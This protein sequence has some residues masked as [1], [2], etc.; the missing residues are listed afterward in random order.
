MDHISH[1]L[2]KTLKK[3]GL[4]QE[5]KASLIV[6]H[7]TLWLHEHLPD[8]FAEVRVR[9]CQDKALI[10]EVQH[11]TAAQECQMQTAELLTH[12]QEE[13]GLAEEVESIRL[14]RS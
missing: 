6:H 9:K 8:Y 4:M 11:S 3:H 5:A 13:C 2:P 10:I 12:L 14:V 7:A 1:L